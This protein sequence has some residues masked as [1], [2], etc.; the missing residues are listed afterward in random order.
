MINSIQQDA[1]DRMTFNISKA[2]LPY[3]TEKDRRII[4]AAL[5]DGLG[6][7]G[8]SYVSGKT[9][10]SRN[11]ISKAIPEMLDRIKNR[12]DSEPINEASGHN[13]TSEETQEGEMES[14]TPRTLTLEELIEQFYG[15]RT[16]LKDEERQRKKG[17]GR[18]RAIEHNPTLIETVEKI[19]EN[20]TYGNPETLI[21]YTN[22]SLRDIS[23]ILEKD[24]KIKA[25]RNVVS[26]ILE[27]LGY[28][29]QQNRKLE[30]VGNDH[31][32]R[33][34]QFK[35]INATAEAY[36]K[37]GEP[38][39]S[40][41]CKKK[42]HLGNMKNNGQEYRKKKDGRRVRDHDYVVP[43]L[44]SVA[45][46]GVYTLNN[47]TGFVNLGVSHDT[48]EF[49]VASIRAWWFTTGKQTFPNA[50]KL[51]ICS[52]GGGSNNSRSHLYKVSLAK[53][54]KEIGL[55]IEI[56][57]FPPG[58]SKWNKIEHRLFSYISRNWAGKP[59]V[60]VQTV[61]KLIGSTT[62][63][64]GLKVTCI[65]DTTHYETGVKVSDEEYENI[66]IEWINVGTSNKWNYRI[67]GLKNGKS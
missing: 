25:S 15:R 21:T 57:H 30:Q 50:T 16:Q 37:A 60:D 49:S 5:A 52:D 42:E 31:I 64:K 54:A 41:D 34:D 10:M 11:T 36:L 29:K 63:K 12:V 38:V 66:D 32:D 28:S 9:D 2:V 8:V 56:S 23:D 7:G 24:Y 47:N 65:T 14:T 33:D 55:E 35:H 44:G 4:A 58:T 61:V 59:L 48:P 6:Y 51:Y 19:V 62:T 40:I 18:K 22:L 67:R 46:Y 1:I 3:S 17:G 45:P 27:I 39:I 13:P 20:S 43:E 26:D 53:L